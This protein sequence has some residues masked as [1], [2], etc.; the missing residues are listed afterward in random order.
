ML[1]LI[2]L[3]CRGYF[4]VKKVVT[5]KSYL[6]KK[7]VA[8]VKVWDWEM[9]KMQ[10]SDLELFKGYDMTDWLLNKKKKGSII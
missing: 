8:D 1:I 9:L 6:Y 10:N 3:N 4:S 2:L 7:V 5:Q